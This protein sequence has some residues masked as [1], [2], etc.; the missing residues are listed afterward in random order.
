M[1]IEILIPV[2]KIINLT[3]NNKFTFKPKIRLYNILMLR[4]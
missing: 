4:H 3:P 1:D 2:D